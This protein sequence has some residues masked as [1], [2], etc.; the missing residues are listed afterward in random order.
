MFCRVEIQMKRSAQPEL[1]APRYE[2]ILRSRV[3]AV[4]DNTEAIIK[5]ECGRRRRRC[6]RSTDWGEGIIICAEKITISFQK[7]HN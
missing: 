3:M 1:D 4:D 6:I 2:Y 7:I 5:Q